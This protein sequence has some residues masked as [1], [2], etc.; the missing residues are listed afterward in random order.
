[1][2]FKEVISK[3]SRMRVKTSPR[4]L[5]QS[6]AHA[7]LSSLHSKHAVISTIMK[8]HYEL[9]DLKHWMSVEKEDCSGKF[10]KIRGLPTMNWSDLWAYPSRNPLT[11]QSYANMAFFRWMMKKRPLLNA[12]LAKERLDWAIAH[13]DW[14]Y[15]PFNGL[16]PLR[17]EW[18]E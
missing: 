2:T 15:G 10:V 6:I 14:T 5:E 7:L 13:K 18:D 4:L 12:E 3:A 8:K 16:P 9:V 1:M 11:T 17:G